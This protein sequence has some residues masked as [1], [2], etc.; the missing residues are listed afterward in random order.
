MKRSKSA[1]MSVNDVN[2]VCVVYVI[3]VNDVLCKRG[4]RSLRDFRKR[5]Y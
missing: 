4:L 1:I 5:C 3:F 2:V